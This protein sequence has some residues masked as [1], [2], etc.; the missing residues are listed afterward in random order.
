MIPS[1][2]FSASYQGGNTDLVINKAHP[3]PVPKRGEVLIKVSA[4]GGTLSLLLYV[5]YVHDLTTVFEVCHSDVAILS[6]V[7][8]DSRTYIMGHEFCGVPVA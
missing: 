1:T 5:R 8:L 6:G 3:V 7:A 4:S 2:M